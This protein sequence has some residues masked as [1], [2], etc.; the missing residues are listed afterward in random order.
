M[1]SNV[2]PSFQFAVETCERFYQPSNMSS[3]AENLPRRPIAASLSTAPARHDGYDGMIAA[4][5]ECFCSA[6]AAWAARCSKAG[7]ARARCKARR[8]CWSDADGRPQGTGQC[9]EVRLN[10]QAGA[11][12]PDIAVIA[13]KPQSFAAGFAALKPFL[14]AKTVLLSIARDG[15]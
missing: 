2:R 6:R 7:C 8:S 14:S 15:P 1:P 11:N 9:R 4:R 13:V 10:P 12:A 3:G 5:P